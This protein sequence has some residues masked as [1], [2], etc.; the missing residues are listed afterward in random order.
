VKPNE[1][2][3]ELVFQHVKCPWMGQTDLKEEGRQ[4]EATSNTGQSWMKL[5]EVPPDDTKRDWKN[6]VSKGLTIWHGTEF[7]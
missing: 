2:N 4:P 6:N 1:V 7:I 5:G 3:K